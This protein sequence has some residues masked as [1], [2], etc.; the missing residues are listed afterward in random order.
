MFLFK[1]V[2]I[3]GCTPL[4]SVQVYTIHP[5]LLP[6]GQ[7]QSQVHTMTL[8]FKFRNSDLVLGWVGIHDLLQYKM[9]L[10]VH[11][12]W[13]CFDKDDNLGPCM[14]SPTSYK[15]VTLSTQTPSFDLHI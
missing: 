7:A 11:V 4:W 13:F 12:I 14:T 2:N 9:T 8:L 15:P 3:Q 6:G 1:T 5:Q 10:G